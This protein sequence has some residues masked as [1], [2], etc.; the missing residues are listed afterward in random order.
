M[1]RVPILILLKRTQVVLFT[2]VTFHSLMLNSSETRQTLTQR[3]Q[4]LKNETQS[5]K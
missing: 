4:A 2:G 1:E 3:L 5:L